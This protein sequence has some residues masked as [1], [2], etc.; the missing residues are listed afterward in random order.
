MATTI[1]VRTL[2][3]IPLFR[4]FEDSELG[5]I[6]QIIA[7]ERLNKHQLIVREGDPGET[8]YIILKGSVAVVHG[9]GDGKETI[10]SILKEGEFF[11]EMTILDSSLP[12]SPGSAEFVQ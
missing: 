6:S 5:L 9:A 3:G 10:L 2:R 7:T 11:G 1:D 12:L 8:F 4:D